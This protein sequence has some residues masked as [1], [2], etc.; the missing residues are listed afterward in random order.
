MLVQKGPERVRPGRVGMASSRDVASRSRRD[1]D[2][3][4]LA[5][6]GVGEEGARSSIRARSSPT[7]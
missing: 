4:S 7:G 6:V 5:D 2:F 3:V 1:V